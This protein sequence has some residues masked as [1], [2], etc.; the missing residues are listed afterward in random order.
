MVKIG[1]LCVPLV[2]T[3]KECDGR[4]DGQTDGFAVNACKACFAERCNTEALTVDVQEARRTLFEMRRRAGS[5]PQ[6]IVCLSLVS[7]ISK[8]HGSHLPVLQNSQIISRSVFCWRVMT[9]GDAWLCETTEL[10]AAERRDV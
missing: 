2:D 7:M 6:A 3:I 4:T 5:S 10:L 8:L 1:S 9:C